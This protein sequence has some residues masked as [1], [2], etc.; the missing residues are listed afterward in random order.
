VWMCSREKKMASPLRSKKPSIKRGQCF[1]DLSLPEEIL[2][3]SVEGALHHNL[4]SML[5]LVQTPQFEPKA[6][7]RPRGTANGLAGKGVRQMRTAP[8]H[9]FEVG[10]ET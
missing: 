10:G 2:Y 9:A 6:S 8:C 1:W 4:N 3:F 5:I 7:R